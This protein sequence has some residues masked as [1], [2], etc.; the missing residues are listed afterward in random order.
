MHSIVIYKLLDPQLHLPL[1]V[2]ALVI[3]V[4]FI[5][6]RMIHQLSRHLL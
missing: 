6:S 2:S 1:Q 4:L 5:P 3:L